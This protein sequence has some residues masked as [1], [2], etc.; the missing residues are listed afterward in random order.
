MTDIIIDF[1]QT[2]DKVRKALDNDRLDE[3]YELIEGF[4][5]RNLIPEKSQNM[6][7]DSPKLYPGGR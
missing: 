4:V 2:Y 7:F 6:E 3:G 5:A 1:H